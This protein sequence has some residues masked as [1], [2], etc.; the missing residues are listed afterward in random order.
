M[1][2]NYKSNRLTPNRKIR[3]Q[4]N[5]QL[6]ILGVIALL[7]ISAYLYFIVFKPE[8]EIKSNHF[9]SDT[10]TQEIIDEGF[11]V[12]DRI[13]ISA[14]LESD[15]DT[16]EQINVLVKVV[17]TDGKLV[18]ETDFKSGTNI[19]RNLTINKVLAPG[20]YSYTIESGSQKA[21]GEF[22]IE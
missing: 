9:A 2:I 16:D 21:S 20:E 13:T 15:K 17:D 6:I 1:K 8:F 10:Q 19:Q 14:I 3:N 18:Y 11:T 7:I 22:E 5:S 4:N 12:G